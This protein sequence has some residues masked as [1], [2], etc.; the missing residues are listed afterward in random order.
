MC[1]WDSTLPEPLIS[2]LSFITVRKRTFRTAFEIT[3]KPN[4][5]TGE[6]GRYVFF[7]PY[8]MLVSHINK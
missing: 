4:E 1:L 7:S 2:G 8:G 3:K 5:L 6:R